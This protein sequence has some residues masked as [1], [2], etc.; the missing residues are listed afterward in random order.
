MFRDVTARRTIELALEDAKA[1]AE[2]AAEV[3]S[4]F[5]AN[6]S[7]ELRTPLTSILGFS[8]MLGGHVDPDGVRFVE[9]VR[10]ASQALLSIVNDVLDFS[11]LEAGQVEIE[12]R[13]CDPFQIINDAAELL[14]PQAGAKSVELQTLICPDVPELVMLDDA[15]VRQIVLNLVGNAVKFTSA[16][17]VSVIVSAPSAGRLRC[18]VKDTGPGIPAERLD[19]LF[20]RFSQVDAS[21]TRAFGGTGLGLAICKGL[22]EAMNGEVGVESRLG[23]GST[24]WFELPAEWAADRPGSVSPDPSDVS[25][26][27]ARLLIVDD[28]PT[29]RELVRLYLTAFEVETTEAASGEEAVGLA[30]SLPFDAILMDLRMPGMTGVEAAGLIRSGTGPNDT[31]PILAFTADAASIRI[32]DRMFADFDGVVAKPVVVSDLFNSLAAALAADV[33]ETD[34]GGACLTPMARAF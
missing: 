10:T 30:A 19:R 29:N 13:A 6:M 1:A 20:Q 14:A 25:L 15:R 32:E 22:I 24:F 12:R 3:K 4:E 21:T 23:S 17:S 28:N 11:K 31:T 5:L 26:E 18:E 34:E 16:G 27:G 7:H 33:P 2:A 9:R 8:E